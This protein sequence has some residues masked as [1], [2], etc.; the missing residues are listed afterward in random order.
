MR[1]ADFLPAS[2]P[3]EPSVILRE[4]RPPSEL[5]VSVDPSRSRS[6]YS[7]DQ[8]ES[9]VWPTQ[10]PDGHSRRGGFEKS[11][12]GVRICTMRPPSI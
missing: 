9:P 12:A 3:G 2:V 11:R 10:T 4:R 5:G 6:A 7:H 8:A 1:R